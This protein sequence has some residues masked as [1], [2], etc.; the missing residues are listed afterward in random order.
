MFQNTS[1]AITCLVIVVA[2]Q[3]QEGELRGEGG[4]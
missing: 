3:S 1:K 4:T 2:T